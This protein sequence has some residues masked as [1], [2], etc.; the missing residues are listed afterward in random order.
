[1]Q[2]QEGAGL[3]EG[4]P[5]G[6]VSTHYSKGVG[7]GAWCQGQRCGG[8][9]GEPCTGQEREAW[10]TPEVGIWTPA[11]ILCSASVDPPGL[12]GD[13][14]DSGPWTL[15]YLLASPAQPALP[16]ISG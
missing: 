3:Q 11:L 9:G 8:L 14:N 2:G 4:C 13:S 16:G 12:A 7:K 6:L 15:V 1:M 10:A 5:G